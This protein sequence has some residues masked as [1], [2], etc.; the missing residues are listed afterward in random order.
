MS[1]LFYN[2][3]TDYIEKMNIVGDDLNLVTITNP[4][5]STTLDCTLGRTF[6]ITLTNAVNLSVTIGPAPSGFSYYTIRI[7]VQ[8]TTSGNETLTWTNATYPT[9]GPTSTQGFSTAA[10]AVDMFEAY[11][12]NGGT[13]WKVARIVRGWTL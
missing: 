8:Q 12:F 1:K 6:F 5:V 3:Q 13:S 9:E 2:K 7:F 11:T 4:G 10:N